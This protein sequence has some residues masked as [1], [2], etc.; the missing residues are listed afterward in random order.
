ML[1]DVQ[2]M[3]LDTHLERFKLQNQANEIELQ[4]VLIEYSELL[5]EYKNL[6]KVFDQKSSSNGHVTLPRKSRSPYVLVLVDGNGYIFNNELVSEKEEGGMKA[7]RMLNEAVEK[8]LREAVPEASNGRIVVRVYADLT[9]LSKS[10]AKSKLVGLEK[11]SLA[12]FA[13]GFTRAMNLFDFVDA[14][15]EEGT[16]F[17]IKEMFKLAADDSN[18][19]HILY[20]ACH[21]KGYLTQI[22][23]YSGMR[24][25]VTLVQGS[26]FDSEFL[27]F[28]LNV[29]HFPTVFRWN[30]HS[31]AP[32]STTKPNGV[33]SDRTSTPSKTA[34]AAKGQTKAHPTRQEDSW[35]QTTQNG[36]SWGHSTHNDNSWGHNESMFETNE[37]SSSGSKGWGEN[38]RSSWGNA[39]EESKQQGQVPCKYFQKGFCR[40]GKNCKYDHGHGG[41]SK[42]P[43]DNQHNQPQPDG[44]S[45]VN[46]SSSLPPT[47]PPNY[48]PLNKD[49]KRIDIYIKPPTQAEWAVY[50]DRFRRQKP[51]NSHHLQG[52]CTT[53]NCPYDHSPLEP[54]A[55]HCLK[56][57]LKCNPC[58]KKGACRA[59]DCF[60]GHICQKDECV[61]HIKGCK[62]KADL[63]NVD[64]KMISLV[65]AEEDIVH[66]ADDAN[67]GAPI[68][69]QAW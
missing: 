11:R 55:H 60:Y 58:P 34:K 44:S 57:V 14:L 12:A 30:G 10:L 59:A 54:E 21:D 41:F 40:Y 9:G 37:P 26:G 33:P 67:E 63:H 68:D 56:Y 50:N 49:N 64:P 23:P 1:G 18:C 19:S 29:T 47:I 15:D 62:M 27:Q 61:G 39:P 17:K 53:F 36:D 7:A 43:N 69:S 38:N 13:A 5:E 48:I 24:N 22:V 4:K 8:Y 46:I 66:A 2:I 20:A 42:P 45:R 31:S 51:C 52:G 16:K 35:G 32:S 25:K 3:S 6:K 65:P 28:S